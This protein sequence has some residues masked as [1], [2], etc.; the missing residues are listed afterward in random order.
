MFVQLCE[1][2][3]HNEPFA[4]HKSSLLSKNAWNGNTE[5]KQEKQ[6]KKMVNEIM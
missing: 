1:G 6:K 5:G 4:K 3:F 2:K